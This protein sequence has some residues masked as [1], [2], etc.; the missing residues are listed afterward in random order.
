MVKSTK[1]NGGFV[2]LILVLLITVAVVGG[3]GYFFLVKSQTTPNRNTE[4]KPREFKFD[5]T[6]SPGNDQTEITT[7]PDAESTQ[8]SV[9]ATPIPT[10]ISKKDLKINS[11]GSV[12][13]GGGFTVKLVSSWEQSGMIY[14]DVLLTN[15]Y[16]S[17]LGVGINE[18]TL[19]GEGVITKP[20]SSKEVGVNPGK[21]E[22]VTMAFKKIPNSP[23]T[24]EYDHPVNHQVFELG[25]IY[26]E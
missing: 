19:H 3:F 6:T 1:Y 17:L 20:T 10:V 15:N 8:K 9:T 5:A 13:L 14:A 18:F 22:S 12:D 7:N 23:Y 21:S 4:E 25:I 24:L 26:T 11:Y 2:L 16:N